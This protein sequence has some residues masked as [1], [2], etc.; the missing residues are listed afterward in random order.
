M[1]KS[2]HITEKG[3]ATIP[4]ELREK[5]DLKPGDEVIWMDTEDGIVVRKRTRTG[6]RGMLVP[7]DLSDEKRKE[8]AD[9]LSER[10][11][12]RRDRNYEEV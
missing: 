6:G 3:Q 2:T 5:Y 10:V 12:Q 7:D 11:R 1:S 8:V 4:K 9:A